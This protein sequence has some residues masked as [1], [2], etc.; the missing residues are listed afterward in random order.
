MAAAIG[1]SARN[2]LMRLAVIHMRQRLNMF[3]LD[4]HFGST[5]LTAVCAGLDAAAKAVGHAR[6]L[7]PRC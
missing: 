6:V 1:V 2:G 3:Q 4:K 7:D 5:T